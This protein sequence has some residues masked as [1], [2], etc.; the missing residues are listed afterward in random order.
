MRGTF[1]FSLFCRGL[2]L[3]LI[4]LSVVGCGA[5]P[6]GSR[7]DQIESLV[8]P[9]LY[10]SPTPSQ[11]PTETPLPS[12]TP[13][14]TSTPI[15][16]RTPVPSPTASPLPTAT[17]LPTISP[18]CPGALPGQLQI[19]AQAEVNF[20]QVSARA[21][22]GFSARKEHVLA[23][24]RIVEIIGGPRCA[25]QAVWWEIY[26]AGTISSGKYLEYEAWMP[27]ADADTY[28]LIQAP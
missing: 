21:A 20:Y 13:T 8:L 12:A 6:S 5:N 1:R 4:I 22:P 14:S 11:T 2:I 25:D 7:G 18:N 24:G 19:G 9:T 16:T 10:I 23:A 17:P 15:P 26:F 27:E 3:G 28:Y